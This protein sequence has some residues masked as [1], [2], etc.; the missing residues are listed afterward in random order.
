M[1]TLPPHI[2]QNGAVVLTTPRDTEP[3]G[4]DKVVFCSQCRAIPIQNQY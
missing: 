2:K 4:V 1:D 3:K